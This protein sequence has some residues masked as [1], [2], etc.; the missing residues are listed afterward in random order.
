MTKRANRFLWNIHT[1]IKK[2]RVP[3]SDEDK[4]FLALALFG[5]CGEVANLIKKKW[6]GDNIPDFDAKLREELGDVYAYLILFSMAYR[7]DLKVTEQF[8]NFTVPSKGNDELYYLAS[9]LASKV[10]KLV[11][12]VLLHWIAEVESVLDSYTWLMAI[13]TQGAL[14]QLASC[15]KVDLDQVLN[16]E[17]IPK[18]QA[19]WGNLVEG[20]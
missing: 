6:R 12:S 8:A 7:I 17:I 18:I 10:G 1:A 11:D 9:L 5:E 20:T 19:L 15:C 4:R 16:D 2:V 3:G 13:E 14:E